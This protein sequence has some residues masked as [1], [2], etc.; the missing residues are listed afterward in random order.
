M[1]SYIPAQIRK[2]VLERDRGLCAY[3][4]SS[5]KLMGITFELDHIVPE[6]AEGTATIDNLCL[7]CPNCNRYKGA[8]QTALDPIS[9]SE[10]LLFHPLNQIWIEH[11]SWNYDKT[12]LIGLT[13]TGRATI[14]ALRINRP[15]IVQL[16]Y[17]WVTLDLHP[18]D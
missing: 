16:R 13:P 11:F 12:E 3:C 7:S 1:S 4:R 8:K 10:V 15:R 2:H 18:P 6:A 14:Q 17:Y 9:K 5:E